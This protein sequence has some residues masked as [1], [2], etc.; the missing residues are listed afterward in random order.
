[1][2]DFDKKGTAEAEAQDS[3][4]FVQFEDDKETAEEGGKAKTIDDEIEKI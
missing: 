1:M 4:S 2:A 3:A